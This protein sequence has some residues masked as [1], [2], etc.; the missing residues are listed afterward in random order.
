[1]TSLSIKLSNAIKSSPGNNQIG[2][3]IADDRNG[4]RLLN[5]FGG[6][7]S[8]KREP[9]QHLVQ[10]YRQPEMM[11]IFVSTL[12]IFFA[13]LSLRIFDDNRLTSWQ[14]VFADTNL[15]TFTL[16]LVAGLL[17]SV[18]LSSITVSRTYTTSLLFLL[19]FI[20]GLAHWSNP[21]MIIDAARY[22]T[23]AKHLEI[24]GI[25]YFFNQWGKEIAPWT[26]LPLMPFIYGVIFKVFGENRFGI[27]IINTFFFSGTVLVTYF[28]G[29]NLWSHRVG[30]YGALMLL[31]I[32]YLHAQVPLMMVDV[33]SM[34]FLTLAVFLYIRA[35]Q[36]KGVE[37]AAIA[38]SSIALAML[39]KYS[40]WL[41]LS[42]L[43]IISLVLVL[44][45]DNKIKRHAIWQQSALV[46]GI[47][48]LLASLV[49][50]WRY[51]VF[52]KQIGLLI[53]Y[54]L[55]ILGGWTESF[56]STFLFQVYPLVSLAAV[57]SIYFAF[58]KMDYRFLIISWML[59]LLIVLDI[60][61][62][63]YAIIVFPMLALMAGYA[64][65]HI[66]EARIRRYLTLSILVSASMI[67]FFGNKAFLGGSSASNIKIAGEYINT[68]N[69]TEVEVIPLHQVKSNVN[70]A[71]S[72]PLLDLVTSKK[73]VYRGKELTHSELNKPWIQKST[74]RF[75]WE[76]KIPAFYRSINETQNKVY[77]IILSYPNQVLP[78]SVKSRL[79]NFYRARRFDNQ[80]GIFQYTTI[81]DI[82]MPVEN[83]KTSMA[84]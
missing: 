4:R 76:Y 66:K 26:D 46:A 32:P 29:K 52:A 12:C 5:P 55:P 72:I 50:F 6:L 28:T 61:R 82:Y 14:W 41:M 34:F 42:I 60:E 56:V 25:G 17:V 3:S 33:P 23:Q 11:L 19:S 21:E 62:I 64:L 7:V 35:I 75:S 69:V 68:L 36:G 38:A 40:I 8:L 20:T 15:V 79:S 80:E 24:H 13:L 65:S 30:L 70:P 49:M 71:L 31:A 81:V 18:R 16:L 22:F 63:R 37:T 43:P 67:S 54:Q 73:V 48:F 53:N 47:L 58:R 45:S 44:E 77:A 78:E 27:Q 84:L 83:K 2:G 39:S 59:A 9:T 74:L 10:F 51:E 1:M 57:L